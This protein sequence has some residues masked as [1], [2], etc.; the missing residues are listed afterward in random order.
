MACLCHRLEDL[1]LC[2]YVLVSLLIRS[3]T[4]E[5]V[6]TLPVLLSCLTTMAYALSFFLPIILREN[7]GFSIAEAQ[8]L[9]A[10]QYVAAAIVMWCAAWVGDRYHVRGPVILFS[11]TL[12]FIGLPL[13]VCSHI[14][15]A[16]IR[17]CCAFDVPS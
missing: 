15:N 6:L 14:D 3:L 5:A 2:Y 9:S 4:L 7:M 12:T 10:P 17:D 1:E 13:M 8:C 16:S 11:C